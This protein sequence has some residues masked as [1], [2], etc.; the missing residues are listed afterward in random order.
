MELL[1]VARMPARR[2]GNTQWVT[3]GGQ[4]RQMDPIE[5]RQSDLSGETRMYLGVRL[6]GPSFTQGIHVFASRANEML[7]STLLEHTTTK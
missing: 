2:R 4:L 1:Y 5:N 7:F 6:R 3:L